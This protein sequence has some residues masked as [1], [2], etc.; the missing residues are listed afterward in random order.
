MDFL[1]SFFK[2]FYCQ[3]IREYGDRQRELSRQNKNLKSG[4]SRKLQAFWLLL[5]GVFGG[6]R[7][8]FLFSQ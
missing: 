2:R 3:E 4:A 7:K 1:L 6:E 5:V 8:L